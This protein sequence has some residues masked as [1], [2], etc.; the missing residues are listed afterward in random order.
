MLSVSVQV[1][2]ILFILTE[3]PPRF[4]GMQTHAVYLSKYFAEKGY[5]IEVLTYQAIDSDMAD[6]AG[7]Y[8]LQCSFPVRRILSRIGYR[9]NLCLVSDAAQRFQP[10]LI[11]ASN[12]FYGLLRHDLHIPVLCRSVGNDVLRPWISYPFRFGSRFLSHAAFETTLYTWFK[13]TNFPEWIEACFRAKRI[14]LMEESLRKMSYIFANS[15]FTANILKERGIPDSR[16]DIV[17]GGVDSQRFTPR[18]DTDALA[19]RQHLGLPEKS[20]L[21]MTACRLVA[22]KGL[23]FLLCAVKK[24]RSLIPSA[25][26][27]IVGDGK[28][29]RKCQALSRALDIE[30]CVI[31]AGRIAHEQIHRYYWSADVFVLASRFCHNR[32]TGMRDVE[33]MGRVLCEANA[34]GVPVIASNSGGIPSVVTHEENGLLFEEGNMD[35]FLTYVCRICHDPSFAQALV[36]NGLTRA[37]AQFDWSVIMQRHERGMAGFMEF[38]DASHG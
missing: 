13:R 26:L 31:F 22:K 21:L 8:D 17:V 2:R 18:H 12:V 28:E 10:D 19:L 20:F 32:L 3:F 14:A 24:L 35:D 23:D 29:R 4:G 27:V 15:D 33:T 6:E 7:N 37:N 25:A 9:H 11:Y 34:A 30:Q 38:L 1:H 36:R 16:I 5:D